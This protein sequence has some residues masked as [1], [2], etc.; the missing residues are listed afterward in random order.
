MTFKKKKLKENEGNGLKWSYK[1]LAKMS[2][3]MGSPHLSSYKEKCLKSVRL[4]F[5]GPLV[6]FFG[7]L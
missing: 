2:G 4:L 1:H 5:K 7:D 3:S 6:F